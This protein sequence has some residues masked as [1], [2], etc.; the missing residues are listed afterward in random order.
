MIDVWR[1]ASA[2]PS[3]KADDTT[4]KGAELSG[5][6]WNAIGKPMLYCADSPALACLETLVHLNNTLP[7]NRYLVRVRI[8]QAVWRKRKV[9]T[10]KELDPQWDAQPASRVS[11]EMG[12][13][14]L[15]QQSQAI[16]V[17]PS[18]I[19]VEQQVVLI[20]PLHADT[21]KMKCE[22]MRKWLYDA[23]ARPP[24]TT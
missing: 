14:W 6:R 7:L 10:V 3:Y 16:L 19:V 9:Y 20:N 2:T 12:N 22:V 5:G 21:H 8:P 15:S 1:I 13:T 4:G 17:V 23:R 24:S 18:S 11:I